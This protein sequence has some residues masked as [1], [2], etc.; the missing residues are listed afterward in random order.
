MYDLW[1][2][3]EKCRIHPEIQINDI[4]ADLSDFGWLKQVSSPPED[5][6]SCG[7]HVFVSKEPTQEVTEKYDITLE[8]Y[9]EILQRLADELTFGGCD[10]CN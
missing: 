7:G 5:M 2:N 3:T 1:I 8:E 9:A 6:Q 10:W 4:D